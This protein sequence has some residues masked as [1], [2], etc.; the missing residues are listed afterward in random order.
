MEHK[1]TME[2]VF[3]VWRQTPGEGHAHVATSVLGAL[4][5]QRLSAQEKVPVFNHLAACPD[6]LEA[7]KTISLNDSIA[8]PAADGDEQSGESV[9][10][11]EPA[12]AAASPRAATPRLRITEDKRHKWQFIIRQGETTILMLEVKPEY[13]PEFENRYV[14]VRDANGQVICSGQIVSGTVSW[15]IH[16]EITHPL[17]LQLQQAP[18]RG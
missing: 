16:E 14:S 4:A 2:Q 15:E 11:E 3:E 1:I 9:F 7:L 5:H 8:P 6:C 17:R 10:E 13:G 18:E 12:L